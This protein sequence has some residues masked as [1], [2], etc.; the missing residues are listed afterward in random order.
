MLYHSRIEYAYLS[1]YIS[2]PDTGRAKRWRWFWTECCKFIGPQLAPVLEV[3]A[4]DWPEFVFE[5][6]KDM[7]RYH[8]H[9]TVIRSLARKPLK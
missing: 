9:I 8:G 4:E 5:H 3:S 1:F 2:G 6:V 7:E